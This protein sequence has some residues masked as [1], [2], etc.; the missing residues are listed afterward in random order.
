MVVE[1]RGYGRS[2]PATPLLSTLLTDAEPF[3]LGT[4]LGD[5]LRLASL[6]PD[7]PPLLFG[8]SIGGHVAVH[9]ATLG[10]SRAAPPHA[11]GA[12]R[13][14]ILDSAVASVR[15]W[16]AM[17][18]EDAPTEGRPPMPAGLHTAGLLEN[19]EK[20]RATATPLLV[21]HGEE[22]AIVPP[23]QAELLHRASAAPAERK[24]CVRFPRRGHNDLVHDP[25]YWPSVASF[26]ESVFDGG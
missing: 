2:P 3:V 13:A 8:R 26:V 21:L 12:F 6:P 24:R 22:D 4:V 11:R 5:A 10:A 18:P 7:L 16:T 14:L 15:H 17:V 20:L 25:S 1:Y 9:L 23:F 19:R